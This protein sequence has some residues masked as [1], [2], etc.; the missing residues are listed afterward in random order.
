MKRQQPISS[1][2]DSLFPST[3]VF[4]AAELA[5]LLQQRVQ[6]SGGHPAV[7]EIALMDD[8]ADREVHVDAGQVHQLER[9]HAEAPGIAHHRIDLSSEERR[10][11]KECVSACRSRWSP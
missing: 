3:T 10:V 11:G 9:S 5:A 1:V 6:R 7:E 8:L 2:T 4:R